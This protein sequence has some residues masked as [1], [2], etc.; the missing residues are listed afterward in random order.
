MSPRKALENREEQ[1]LQAAIRVF[2]KK[3]YSGGTTSEIAK[4]ANISEGTIFR[5]FRNKK[6]ILNKIIFA[7][8]DIV[9]KNFVMKPIKKIIQENKEKNYKEILKRILKDRIE[10]LEKNSELIIVVMGEIAHNEEMQNILSDNISKII[11]ELAKEMQSLGNISEE[12]KEVNLKVTLRSILGMI[13]MHVVQKNIA[14]ELI[15]LTEEEQL[16][17]MV[18][19]ILYGVVKK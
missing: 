15:E 5:Y 7:C 9:S 1:I 10:I 8:S 17:N 6:E 14:P 16:D 4:E 3:G 19:I 12:F 13:M 11:N 2:S 18:E